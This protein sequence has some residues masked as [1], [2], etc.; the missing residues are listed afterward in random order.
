MM[1]PYQ[2]S[3]DIT[4]CAYLIRAV[5]RH[6]PVH[7]MSTS[8]DYVRIGLDQMK[9]TYECYQTCQMLGNLE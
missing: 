2:R 8:I 3:I 4:D 6:A 5:K 9:R 7:S 1:T